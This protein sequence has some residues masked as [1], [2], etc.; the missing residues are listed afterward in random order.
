MKKD[1]NE[2]VTFGAL[3]KRNI[4]FSN[5]DSTP[6]SNIQS[7]TSASEHLHSLIQSFSVFVAQGHIHLDRWVRAPL[8]CS[9]TL[10]AARW[11]NQQKDSLLCVCVCV[12]VLTSCP[13]AL[14]IPLKWM[15]N[16]F[17]S[18]VTYSLIQAEKSGM[19]K[20]E[21]G[22]TGSCCVLQYT[23]THTHTHTIMDCA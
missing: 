5:Q 18:P 3:K 12:C 19:N 20:L 13:E 10:A 1:I 6:Q 2:F 21:S 14:R 7:P 4:Y 16:H 15:W 23:H 22:H 9:T 17:A 11:D 8:A